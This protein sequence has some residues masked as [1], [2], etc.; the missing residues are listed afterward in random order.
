MQPAGAHATIG[1][2]QAP[3]PFMRLPIHV[4]NGAVVALGIALIQGVVALAGG[5]LAA[6]SAGTGSICASLADL[7]VA[8]GR[9][10]R[11]VGMA[12]IVAW[13]SQLVIAALRQSGVTMGFTVMALSFC[14]AMALSWGLRAAQLSFIPV[15][16][17][18]FTLAAPPPP[19][20]RT[21]LVH[22]A[23][24]A[25]GGALYFAWAVLTARVL[26]PR[27]RTLALANALAALA[28]LLRS[29]AALHAAAI[30]PDTPAVAPPLQEWIRSQVAL[31]ERLQAARDLLFPAAGRPEAGPAIAVLLQAV[32]MRDTLL[33]GE[34]DL[35]L[36]GHDAAATV[37]RRRLRARSM[38]VADVVESMAQAL[39]EHGLRAAGGRV[40]ALVDDEAPVPA[41]AGDGPEAT[42]G[43]REG[44]AAAAATGA[45]PAAATGADAVPP[46]GAADSALPTFAVDDPRHAL[47]AALNDRARHMTEA[48]ARMQAAL[49]GEATAQPLAHAELKVF[50][51]AEGWPLQ[52]LKAQLSP[53]SPI[54]RHAVRLSVAL[55]TAYFVGLVLPWASHP[56]WL[57]L[58]VAVVMR[59]NLEQTLARR[60]DRVLG[61]MIG[62]LLVLALGHFARPWVATTAFLVAVGIAHSYATA[63]YIVTCAAASVMALM[64]AHLAQPVAGFGA[65]ERIGDTVLGATLA[66]G[67]SYLWPWWERRG[68]ARLV[69]R[70]LRSLCTLSEE[71]LRLPEPGRPDTTLRLARREVYEAVGAI[72]ATAQRTGAEPAA[73]QVP[74]YALAEMLTRCHV[75]MAQLLA[76]RLLL[77]RRR[78][79]LDPAEAAAALDAARTGLQRALR[80]SP[81]AAQTAAASD[82][83]SAPSDAART[84]APADA[85]RTTAPP[86]AGGAGVPGDA[87]GR[88][89]VPSEDVDHIPVPVALP[90]SAVF[91]WLQRRLALAQRAARRV[92]LAAQALRVAAR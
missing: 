88:G 34:L 75:L 56:H 69:D 90:D 65:I 30:E 18:V 31:D 89:A 63:R 38:A 32:E 85:G 82:R 33:A 64:Q 29:R 7:P 91:P 81:V 21:L 6:L 77:A 35:E 60:D 26:Q 78:A 55:G 45:G 68:V 53:D 16:A 57:V 25:V 9:T 87:S 36:L 71:V 49:R 79:Q 22:S 1:A 28:A 59:G 24:T 48:L 73:V 27:Y 70:V 62:C 86:D 12:A 80:P 39:R 67:F 66:W 83:A 42:P 19:D 52:A 46:G 43:A 92:G 10:W 74:M 8:P 84:S 51:S 76:V 13:A 2:M 3:R 41:A 61:T 50:I 14:A 72:A 40:S 11:R 4:V 15:L 5:P 44:R 20:V 17:L 37:L 23:W 54:F 47:A 58:S